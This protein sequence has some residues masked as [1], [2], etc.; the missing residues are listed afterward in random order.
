MRTNN[1]KGP[2]QTALPSVS[3]SHRRVVKGLGIRRWAEAPEFGRAGQGRSRGLAP[4]PGLWEGTEKCLLI[5]FSPLPFSFSPQNS[6]PSPFLRFRNHGRGQ[7]R[8]DKS[9]EEN[10][11]LWYL[12]NQNIIFLKAFLLRKRENAERK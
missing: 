5:Q 2:R 12:K 9:K 8:A 3:S 11:I 6:C 4:C 7:E 1:I 10:A